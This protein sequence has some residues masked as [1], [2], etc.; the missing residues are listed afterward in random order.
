VAITG[1]ITYKRGGETRD[2][3]YPK[4][5]GEKFSLHWEGGP[6]PHEL[7]NRTDGWVAWYDDF[8]GKEHIR[9]DFVIGPWTDTQWGGGGP[10]HI[11]LHVKD[12]L[13]G[14]RPPM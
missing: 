4:T 6:D 10:S 3:L 9:E 2:L 13:G 11:R 5:D 14:H 7:L 1:K 12:P 8:E